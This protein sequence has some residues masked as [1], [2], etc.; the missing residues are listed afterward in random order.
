[1]A[2]TDDGHQLALQLHDV[3]RRLTELLEGALEGDVT[4]EGARLVIQELA[5]GVEELRVA[6]EEL[7]VQAEQLAIS[8]LAID[9][10]RERY[11]RLFD[12]APDAYVETDPHGKILEANAAAQQLLGVPIRF[13]SGKLVQS[14]LP[15]DDIRAVRRALTQLREVEAPSSLELAVVPRSLPPVPVEARLASHFDPAIGD[16]GEHRVLWLLRDLS[17][18]VKLDREIR[19]LHA[20]VDLL[21][22]LAEVNHLVAGTEHPVDPMLAGLVELA[23]TACAGTS[24]GISLVDSRGRVAARAVSDAV[25]AE[26]CELQLS[27]QGPAVLV[28][29]DGMPRLDEAGE[30]QQ[31]PALTDA[32]AR[33]Q[34]DWI[35]SHPIGALDGDRAGVFNLY[36]RGSPS[37]AQRSVQLLADHAA[38][39]ISN[40]LLFTSATELARQLA[41]ALES[42]GVIDQAKGVLM[43]LQGCDADAAFDIL[44]R[45]SQRENRKLRTI[46]EEIVER[47]R[48]GGRPPAPVPVRRG[49]DQSPS[50]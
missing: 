25:A 39:V 27:G 48:A 29:R 37:G 32:M 35:L 9:A 24:A 22:A 45:A 13:L 44:R 28:L 40:G 38:G 18:R 47:A 46:A 41:T 8:H 33:H 26:L 49:A 1:M 20:D 16:E 14:F 2:S 42:R 17:Q 50:G 21:A 5:T 19:Q 36:G 7:T 6:E 12:F 31:W 4:A 15:P 23:T 34:V 11:A 30:L 43:A 3:G 10:E